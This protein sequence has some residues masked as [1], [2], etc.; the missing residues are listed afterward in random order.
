VG[1][2]IVIV[3]LAVLVIG[4]LAFVLSQPRKGSVEW[5]KREYLRAIDLDYG[6][7][8]IAKVRRFL[9]RSKTG[10]RANMKLHERSL[11]AAGFLEQR[12]IAITNTMEVASAVL[13]KLNPPKN[14]DPF[15]FASLIT[16]DQRE[17]IVITAL[18]TNIDKCEELVRKADLPE[19][20]K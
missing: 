18:P 4:V 15:T 17:M 20:G 3:A 12:E 7:S 1:K 10:D 13:E 5:H 6:E 11:I 16:R 14:V 2:R 9:P 19:S 8:V